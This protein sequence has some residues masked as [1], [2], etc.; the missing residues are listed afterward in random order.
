MD[1]KEY[2]KYYILYKHLI[3]HNIFVN[4]L[5]QDYFIKNFKN[6]IKHKIY[7]KMIYLHR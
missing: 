5:L 6:V 3:I 2:H 7:K 4:N 1:A